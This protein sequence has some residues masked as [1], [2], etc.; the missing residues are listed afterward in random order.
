[1]NFGQ[2]W[3]GNAARAR[4]GLDCVFG[5][6]KLKLG[7][8]EE[9]SGVTVEERKEKCLARVIVGISR[10]QLFALM[11]SGATPN[12]LYSAL[13]RQFS[14]DRERTRKVAKVAAGSR[15]L[16][17][18]NVSRVSV[19]IK[20]MN[21]KMDF[22]VVPNVPFILVIGRPTPKRLGDVLELKAKE[23]RTYYRVL[24]PYF[25]WCRN[26]SALKS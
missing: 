6:G 9:E 21:V 12:V 24:K 22:I 13:S 4:K 15:S 16:V 7:V 20:R 18:E 19:V 3:Q 25:Q 14:F 5:K 11:V 26:I 10:S 23:V 17:K 2:L 1:M 8:V